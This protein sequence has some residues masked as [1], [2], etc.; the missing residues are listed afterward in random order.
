MDARAFLNVAWFGI[1][2]LA[3]VGCSRTDVDHLASIGR[4]TVNRAGAMTATKEGNAVGSWQMMRAG[5]DEI[6]LDARVSARLRWD[7]SL[8]ETPIQ[9]H[10]T[11]GTIELRGT[12]RDLT[13]RRRVVELAETT[14]GVERVVDALELPAKSP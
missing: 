10:A 9:V 5:L 1:I 3:G 14:V 11:G 6:T 7:K 4:K 13:Q 12:V 2:V 8:A